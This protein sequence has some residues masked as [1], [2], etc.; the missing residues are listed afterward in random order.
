MELLPGQHYVIDNLSF[1]FTSGYDLGIEREV[2][3]TNSLYYAYIGAKPRNDITRLVFFTLDGYNFCDLYAD[4]D[5]VSR[6]STDNQQKNRDYIS[7]TV[8]SVTGIIDIQNL[9]IHN[10]TPTTIY[11]TASQHITTSVGTGSMPY[12]LLFTVDCDNGYSLYKVPLQFNMI[13][14]GVLSSLWDDGEVVID[15][16]EL[17]FNESELSFDSNFYI[18][19]ELDIIGSPILISTKSIV[20]DNADLDYNI[21]PTENGQE[22]FPSFFTFEVNYGE[23]ITIELMP[24]YNASNYRFT[25]NSVDKYIEE[26]IKDFTDRE[27]NYKDYFESIS[28]ELSANKSRMF[29][30]FHKVAKNFD[31]IATYGN[32]FAS[33]F[34]MVE[35]PTVTYNLTHCSIED[36][37][38]HA[39][40][41]EELDLIV[42]V[43]EYYVIENEDIV[44]FMGNEDI[45][46]S[47]WDKEQ[48]TIHIDKVT[49]DLVIQIKAIRDYVLSIHTSSTSVDKL[50]YT[51]SKVIESLSMTVNNDV[52]G[53]IVNG[54]LLGTLNIP[55]QEN[56]VIIGLGINDSQEVFVPVGVIINNIDLSQYGED[57]I[58]NLYP[59]IVN[60]ADPTTFEINLYNM[61]CDK[62][63][64]DKTNGIVAIST[65]SG[66]LRE[67]S[68][69]MNPV[70]K[71]ETTRL[72]QFNYVYIP[73]FRR[74]YFVQDIVV[75]TDKL[76]SMSLHVD[77]LMTYKNEIKSQK[78][79]IARNEFEYNNLLIDD[80][81]KTTTEKIINFTQFDEFDGSWFDLSK[82]DEN[83]LPIVVQT[84]GKGE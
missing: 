36:A 17:T 39:T 49:N 34:V 71:F 77:V 57:G 11:L 35:Q 45:T 22:N 1:A 73:A 76:Y 53:V 6:I 84:M 64:V 48:Q 52:I 24:F 62:N 25:E 31:L 81:R 9:T 42:D 2:Q 29:I 79:I 46:E 19:D 61:N 75:I 59:I 66:T 21:I 15:I 40:Y 56:D 4:T 83:N 5:F 69:L 51:G 18:G 55:L 14:S 38:I 63:T 47:A 68:D 7:F 8:V 41:N 70:I 33:R 43:D 3:I 32:N 65:L 74:Y 20:C 72:P 10:I 28:G 60:T 13:H 27:L 80:K 78:G 23:D 30:T 67:S 82:I 58:L 50:D 16:T 26:T 12:V 54:T 37:P 44:I